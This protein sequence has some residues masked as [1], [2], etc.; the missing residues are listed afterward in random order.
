MFVSAELDGGAENPHAILLLG[1]S[2]TH[3]VGPP[4]PPIATH[5][6]IFRQR[7]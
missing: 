2:A 4:H 3:E 6:S 7:L 5:P 1:D